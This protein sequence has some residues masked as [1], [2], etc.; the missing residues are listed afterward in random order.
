MN[1]KPNNLFDL[2]VYYLDLV[3]NG[4]F[5]LQAV[6]QIGGSSIR[7]QF[8]RYR[9]HNTTDLEILGQSGAL[10]LPITILCFVTGSDT[11]EGLWFRFVRLL[12][13]VNTIFDFIPQSH[14]L[15]SGM[16]YGFKSA[17]FTF[18]LL[19]NL[20]CM[21]A[22]FGFTLFRHNDNMGFGSFSLSLFTFFRMATFDNWTNVYYQNMYAMSSNVPDY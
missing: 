13:I 12:F 20:I 10:A 16:F 22:C 3:V 1:L 17:F 5:A 21:Y 9:R 14:I 11:T 6:F 15:L 4:V 2:V 19:F 7:F 8:D 18:L